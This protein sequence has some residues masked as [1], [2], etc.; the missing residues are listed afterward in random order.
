MNQQIAIIGAGI[1]G[2]STAY[3]LV[4]AGY[5]ITVFAK[6]FSP[7]L[8]SNKA[9]AFWF[10]YHVR[11]NARA[12]DWCKFS[13]SFFEQLS[14]NIATGISMVGIIKAVKPNVQD[15]D[16][17][18]NYMP[19]NSYSIVEEK[20]LPNG[21]AKAYLAKVP[22][23]ETQIFLPWLMQELQLLQTNFIQQN[24][25]DIQSIATKF[26]VVINCTALGAKQLCNDATLVAVRGQVL[27]YEPNLINQIFIDNQTPS[28][29]VPRKDAT[30]VG[31][32]YE[33]GVD[34]NSV[35]ENDL[36]IIQAKAEEIL[37]AIQ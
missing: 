33:E 3:T 19:D 6:E 27:L 8:V 23:I 37:P 16:N 20:N 5:N 32:T 22:L 25:E 31:G 2:L 13:Y 24:I 29:M 15:E 12:K 7:N 10:P 28:Y 26:D 4:N 1:S 17:W 36:K 18:L 11:N 14:A 30:I 21:Y 34:S 35:N 9:A